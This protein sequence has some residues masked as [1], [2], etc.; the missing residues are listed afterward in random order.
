MS[1]ASATRMMVS[2]GLA[3]AL[4]GLILVGSYQVTAPRIERN[5]KEALE[6]AVYRVLP[7][8]VSRSPVVLRDGAAVPVEE[9]DVQPGE[10]PAWAGRDADGRVLGYAI[11][12]EGTGF[13]DVAL[14]IFPLPNGVIGILHGQLRQR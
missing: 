13:Q 4:S 14:Y 2:L 3:G 9:A 8:A 11:A 7:G 5:R 10:V 6:A 1:D 12:S